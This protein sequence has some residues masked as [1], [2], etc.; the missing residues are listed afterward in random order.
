VLARAFVG[1]FVAA[2]ADHAVAD[3]LSLAGS[4]PV[5][6][7]AAAPPLAVQ[8]AVRN[9][10]EACMAWPTHFAAP[11]PNQRPVLNLPSDEAAICDDATH[12]R[13]FTWQIG[14]AF[15]M[16][17]LF[18]LVLFGFAMQAV[19]SVYKGIRGIIVSLWRS[20]A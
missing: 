12:P 18:V 2:M 1:A 4:P 16:M 5:F 19:L 10:R 20:A 9:L 14:L 17:A 13:Q 3:K 8:M 11:N 15:A 7:G 6:P